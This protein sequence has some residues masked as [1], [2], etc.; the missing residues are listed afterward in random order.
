MTG[1]DRALREINNLRFS[2]ANIGKIFGSAKGKREK[3]ENSHK[4]SPARW[5]RTFKPLNLF[6]PK[7]PI[8]V[9]WFWINKIIFIAF[10]FTVK[11]N[12]FSQFIIF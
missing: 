12:T 10:G 1:I 3:F 9:S 7:N 5:G 8:I 11:S 6:F 2:T 4:K